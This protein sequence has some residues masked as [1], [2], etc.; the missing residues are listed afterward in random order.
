MNNRDLSTDLRGNFPR[1]LKYIK[2]KYLLDVSCFD[3]VID[4]RLDDSYS[5]FLEFFD[6]PPSLF[7]NEGH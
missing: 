7:M 2:D 1:E 5:R 6:A 3:V 4:Y